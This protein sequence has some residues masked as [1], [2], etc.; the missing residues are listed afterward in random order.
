MF[1]KV[2]LVTRKTRLDELIERFNTKEQAR[3]YI[4]H[5]GGDFDSYVQEHDAY[6]RSLESVRRTIECG[7]KIQLL[8]RDLLS[9]YLFAPS[10]LIV[11]LGQDG[12]V[13]N[14]AKYVMGQPIIAVNPD[15]DRFDGILLP[16]APQQLKRALDKTMAR[17][18][19]MLAVSMA[20]ARLADGQRLLAFND[21]FIGASTH[22]SARYKIDYAGRQESQSSSGIIVSTGAGST[23]WLSSIFNETCGLVSFL[24]GAPP[25]P[26]TMSWE[27]E[28]LLFVVREP[29]VSR[30][31]R[32]SI[33]VG[34][35]TTGSS[36]DLESQM[37]SGGVIFSD[38]IEMDRLEFNSGTIATIG[39]AREKAHL[40]AA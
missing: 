36:L 23:G 39:V 38:G 13:A 3:F 17:Q 15:K 37:P 16:Y 21:L 14:T 27:E 6:Q 30:H 32:A 25:R 10:D 1:E 26:V 7:L 12:L 28:R 20:E 31:S 11:T 4:E 33:V 34:G 22:I 29:F 8:D 18:A 24:G 35:L 9:T 2:V 40:V 5:A 19:R